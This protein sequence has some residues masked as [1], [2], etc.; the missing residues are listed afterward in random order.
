MGLAT[1][2]GIRTVRL[3]AAYLWGIARDVGPIRAHTPAV[4]DKSN[5]QLKVS[6]F[7]GEYG[8]EA[9][10]HSRLILDCEIL[11]NKTSSIDS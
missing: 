3:G 2:I 1:S 4:F 10:N 7:G 9:L 11:A 6:R 8:F 5:R